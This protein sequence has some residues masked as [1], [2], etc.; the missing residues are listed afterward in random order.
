MS[1]APSR[2]KKLAHELLRKN[3]LGRSWRAIS[4][5][6]YGERIHFATL[7]KIARSG[8]EWVPSDPE[9]LR[10]LGLLTDRRLGARLPRYFIKSAEAESWL[11][12]VRAKI[13]EMSEPTRQAL[14]RRR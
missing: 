10:V 8:G 4:L 1:I 9:A 5:D 14:R 2:R 12:G 6:D 7:N 13:K 3:R 11:A